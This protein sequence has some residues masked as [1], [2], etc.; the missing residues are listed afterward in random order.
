MQPENYFQLMLFFL[1]KNLIDSTLDWSSKTMRQWRPKRWCD[2]S[3]PLYLSLSRPSLSHCFSVFLLCLPAWSMHNDTVP[4]AA[5][6]NA[7]HSTPFSLVKEIVILPR[8]SSQFRPI[9]STN[10]FTLE[11]S[12]ARIVTNQ[13]HIK[14]QW[15]HW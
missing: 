7:V 11:K 13:F 5:A 12:V 6:S 9:K 1:K 15:R 2:A 4:T 14:L 3:Q 8:K 10:Y